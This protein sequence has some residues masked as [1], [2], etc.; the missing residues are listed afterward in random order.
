MKNNYIIITPAKNEEK[1]IEK[2]IISVINQ[3]ILP[4]MWVIVDDGS[5]DSTAE[6]VK[7]YAEKYNFIRLV[8]REKGNSRN[9][10]N[11]VY[12]IRRGFDEVKDLEY[13]YYCNLDADVSFK[14]NYFESLLKKFEEDPKLGICGGKVYGL[15]E[16]IFFPQKYADN[17]IP[18]L[19]QFFRRTC[20]QQ[21]GGYYPMIY[22]NEDGYVEVQARRFGWKTITFY[23]NVI[24]HHRITGS[25]WGNKFKQR[26]ISGEIEYYFG[27]YYIY[28]LLRNLPRLFKKPYIIG[29]FAI[30]IGYITPKIIGKRRFVDNK[31]IEY[32]RKE[33]KERIKHFIVKKLKR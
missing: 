29:Y 15:K 13:N 9:F 16:N 8:Q 20:Y 4:L 27:Y 7:S 22:G 21:I 14:S 6:I 10:G 18:G 5:S 31:F 24:F 17:S 32:I 28:H 26:F 25:E 33:Q 11:K 2:A 30:I 1:F 19:T 23:D 12:A 3:T